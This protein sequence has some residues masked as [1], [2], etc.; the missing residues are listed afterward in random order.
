MHRRVQAKHF[1]L[2]VYFV[3]IIEKLQ[4]CMCDSIQVIINSLIEKLNNVEYVA[5]SRLLLY[6]QEFVVTFVI[7]ILKVVLMAIVCKYS[8]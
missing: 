7:F 4:S 1:D 2:S 6:K 3:K 5:I 8:S